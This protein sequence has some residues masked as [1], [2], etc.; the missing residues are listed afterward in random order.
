MVVG[1]EELAAPAFEAVIPELER[2]SSTP[3]EKRRTSTVTLVI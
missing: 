2:L 1:A 3:N